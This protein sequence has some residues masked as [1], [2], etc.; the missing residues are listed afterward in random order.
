MIFSYSSNAFTWFESVFNT[1]KQLDYSGNLGLERSPHTENPVEAG[2]KSMAHLTPL[3][4]KDW[5]ESL[6]KR[7]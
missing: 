4:D 6:E 5:S 7:S 3:F 1:M 2:V